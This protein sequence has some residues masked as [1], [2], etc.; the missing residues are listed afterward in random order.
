[1]PNKWKDQI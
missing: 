1:M